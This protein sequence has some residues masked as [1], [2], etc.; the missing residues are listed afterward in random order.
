MKPSP[1][2]TAEFLAWAAFLA[3]VVFQAYAYAYR[4]TLS[5][6]PRVILQP[7]LQRMGYIAYENI[8]DLHMPLLPLL[9][10]CLQPVV[11]NG[12]TAARLLQLGLLSTT[13]L[14]VFFHARRS[15]GPWGGVWAAFFFVI[16]TPAFQFGKL[17]HESLLAPLYLLFLFFY[18]PGAEKKG[19]GWSVGVGLLGGLTL[20]VKQHAGL[21]FAA[22]LAWQL[23]TARAFRRPLAQALR[24][25]VIAGC[26]AALPLAGYLL[27]QYLIAGTLEGFLYWTIGYNLSGVYQDLSDLSPTLGQLSMV[28]SSALLVPAAFL[29]SPSGE[30]KAAPAW[31]LPGFWLVLAL[32]ASATAYP[33]YGEFHLQPALGLVAILSAYALV[34]ALRLPGPARRLGLGVGLALSFYWLVS[35]GSAYRVVFQPAQAREIHEYT[36]LR[37]LVTQVREVMEPSQR[38]FIFMDDESLSNLYYFTGSPPPELWI[39]H[40][41]WYLVDWVKQRI[42][43]DLAKDPPDWVLYDATW[44]ADTY[45]PE[46]VA[47]LNQHYRVER[48]LTWQGR[49]VSLMRRE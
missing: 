49:R 40:Y 41:P 45:A 6:G 27:Y 36:T 11:G 31:L 10:Q 38:L 12:L 7:W 39:F 20:L 42:L 23:V 37:P 24:E 5:L 46:I 43:T 47:Y 18:T 33:R 44:G 29:V 15:V 9:L 16:W 21:V 32:T 26:F 30:K 1:R 25:V 34:G 13:T 35:V 2:R 17:W 14:L 28:I 4:L 8:S 19:L 3:L 48:S 22:F